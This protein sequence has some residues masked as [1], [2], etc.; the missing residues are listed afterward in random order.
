MYPLIKQKPR[1]RKLSELEYGLFSG[2]NLYMLYDIWSIAYYCHSWVSMLDVDDLAF[3]W[4]QDICKKYN[5]G[6]PVYI[7]EASME[8]IIA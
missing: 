2:L 1:K 8:C 3:I 7:R 5:L 4:H 6:R